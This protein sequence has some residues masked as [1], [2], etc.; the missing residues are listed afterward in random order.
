M[1]VGD[2][3]IAKEGIILKPVGTMGIIIKVWITDVSNRNNSRIH[4]LDGDEH[5]VNNRFLVEAK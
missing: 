5:W 4:W 1:K 3:V 2:L